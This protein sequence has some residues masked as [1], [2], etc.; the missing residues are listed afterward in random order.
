MKLGIAKKLGSTSQMPRFGESSPTACYINQEEEFVAGDDH[1]SFADR[2]HLA[3]GVRLSADNHCQRVCALHRK[4]RI[5]HAFQKID[6]LSKGFITSDQA[7]TGDA[8]LTIPMF[9]L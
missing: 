8:G 7:S 1:G 4:A 6:T 3:V 5:D 2:R 9:P